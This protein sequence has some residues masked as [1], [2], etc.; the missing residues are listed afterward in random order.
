[1]PRLATCDTKLVAAFFV[2]ETILD[3]KAFEIK[4]RLEDPVSFTVSSLLASFIFGLS[5]EILKSVVLSKTKSRV[6]GSSVL[7]FKY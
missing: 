7:T 2:L 6:E 1:M 4:A 3:L 5:F